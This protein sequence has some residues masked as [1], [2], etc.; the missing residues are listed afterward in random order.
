MSENEIIKR[1]V[2]NDE[3]GVYVVFSIGATEWVTV[4]QF[5]NFD[6]VCTW[7]RATVDWGT[8]TAAPPDLADAV[9]ECLRRAAAIARRLDTRAGQPATGKW[10][11]EL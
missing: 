10:E 8:W 6:K 1:I 3:R 2:N 5:A 11:G 7:Q 4:G 9:A